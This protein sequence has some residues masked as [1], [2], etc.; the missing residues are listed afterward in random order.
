[1][2]LGRRVSSLVLCAAMVAPAAAAQQPASIARPAVD[3]ALD[4]LNARA[5][6]WRAATEFLWL[7]RFYYKAS[8]GVRHELGG[9]GVLTGED[10]DHPG[11]QLRSTNARRAPLHCHP[12][13]R[14]RGG[15]VVREVA[16]EH[17]IDGQTRESRS[18]L[19]R[20]NNVQP[21]VCPV[22][23]YDD[24]TGGGDERLNID[25]G[26]LP[27]LRSGLAL[28]RDSLLATLDSTA[29]RLPGD[30]WVAEARV[31]F[32]VDAGEYDRALASARAC[33]LGPMWCNALAGYVL[34]SKHDVAAADSAFT[35]AAAAM[36]PE[37]RC[38]W[39]DLEWLIP[40]G[41]ARAAYDRV[42]CERRDSVDR[43]IWWLA[44]PLYAEPGNERRVEHYRRQLLDELRSRPAHAERDDWTWQRNGRGLA[45][46]L[47]RYGW[48]S[49][50]YWLGIAEDASH[51]GALGLPFPKYSP[52]DRR[53]LEAALFTTFEYK[54]PR[55]HSMA[56]WSAVDDPLHATPADWELTAPL[57]TRL[58]ADKGWWPIEHMARDSGAI[59][60]IPL[61]R[62]QRVFLPRD[63]TVLFAIAAAA[64]KTGWAGAAN[65]AATHLVF[66][67]APDSVLQWTRLTA[68]DST[69]VAWG[70]VPPRPA[71]AG[72]EVLTS[73]GGWASRLRYGV[74]PPPPLS[75]WRRDT[76]AVSEPVFVDASIA[77]EPLTVNGALR[78]MLGTTT[79]TNPHSVGVYW[80]TYGLE[81]TDSVDVAVAITKRVTGV[82][83]RLGAAVGLAHQ[84]TV[85]VRWR[86][87]QPA[88]AGT[89]IPARIPMQARAIPVDLSQLS[90]GDYT[91][92]V[93]MTRAG[94]GTAT[95][96]REFAIAR[97]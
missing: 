19:L 14:A 55:I 34:A 88:R 27:S 42:P 36:S 31:R 30:L 16:P 39:F 71:I 96:A 67:P 81:P 18:D 54:P 76:I 17:I 73:P 69:A 77:A 45:E 38:H 72:L 20:V 10:L 95:G 4:S 40:L 89:S 13:R 91:V 35:A 41:V 57:G 97:P 1:M 6:A 66:S 46:M 5:P 80:E 11:T 23:A 49:Y 7:W 51:Y 94:R 85:S 8:E 47:T 33:G 82:L 75:A 3:A 26:I 50:A 15:D 83:G 2:I 53:T 92:T 87:P 62:T 56:R 52:P 9:G 44:D 22:W 70:L 90:P 74:A 48:P 64:P 43:V 60:D 24:Q 28:A 61:D 68:R 79:L 59:E 65:G 58:A 78:R 21:A 93:S 12:I 84:S 29:R 25:A 32:A 86:E 37:Q 63:S